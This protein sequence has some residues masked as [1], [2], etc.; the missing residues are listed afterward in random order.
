MNMSHEPNPAHEFTIA[1]DGVDFRDLRPVYEPNPNAKVLPLVPSSDPIL[2]SESLPVE[3][4]KSEEIQQLILDLTETM[5]YYGGIGISAVQCG[6]PLDLFI[7][8][9][10]AVVPI[11]FINSKIVGYVE[12]LSS[13]EEGCLS[14][15]GIVVNV[16]RYHTIRIRSTN[17]NGITDTHKYMG[18]SARIIQHEYDHAR[19]RTIKTISSKLKWDMAVKK[20]KKRKVNLTI[21]G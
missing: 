20:A 15:P 10:G 21:Q 19:G 18:L 13:M 7:V 16:D 3:D 14:Y 12:P 2:L 17:E 1:A 9:D 6:Y 11:V 4:V 8:E 5:R